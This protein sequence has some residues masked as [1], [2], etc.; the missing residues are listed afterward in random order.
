M[1]LSCV[2]TNGKIRRVKSVEIHFQRGLRHL[3]AWD[4]K[5]NAFHVFA[6]MKVFATFTENGGLKK[7]PKEPF[8]LYRKLN[9]SVRRP[10]I[11]RFRKSEQSVY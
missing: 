1:F 3:T 5:S 7:I 10:S 6:E 8:G 9:I 4:I 2:Q 11:K